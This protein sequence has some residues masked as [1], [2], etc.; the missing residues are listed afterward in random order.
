[1]LGKSRIRYPGFR[2]VAA[3]A[4]MV[5]AVT[6]V[7]PAA[8]S[9]M[10]STGSSDTGSSD[11]GSGIIDGGIGSI[12]SS[13][14]GSGSSGGP[15]VPTQQCNESTQAGGEG[16][17]DTIHQLGTSGPTSFV[18]DYE[19]QNIPDQI[20]VF[21]EGAL[22]HNTGYIG[23]NINEGTGSVVINVPPGSATSVLVRVTGPG[24]TEWSYTVR[25][26]NT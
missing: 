5:A 12:I 9:A 21:Y 2:N 18:L 17:T 11:T 22:L 25:C 7:A 14:L 1:M 15:S 6:L 4:A 23:D 26:P 3:A 13:I 10:P 16:V 20:E 19:T 24:D 8:A